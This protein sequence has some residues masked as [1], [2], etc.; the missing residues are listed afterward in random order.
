VFIVGGL[1]EMNAELQSV[2]VYNPVTEHWTQASEMQAKRA[3][4]SVSAVNG[5]IYA[6][7]GWTMKD[8]ALATVERY[9][10]TEVQLL[11]CIV[12]YHI[13]N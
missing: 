7:G 10:V 8:G 3:Y 5:C 1:N 9:S 11:L 2:D 13:T 6:I 4:V 12:F